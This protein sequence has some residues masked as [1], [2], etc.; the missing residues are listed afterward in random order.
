LK[1]RQSRTSVPENTEET[2]RL[3]F[4]GGD[5]LNSAV[6]ETQPTLE[7]RRSERQAQKQE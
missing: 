3:T 6:L 5:E 2:N 7:K 4:G 1:S